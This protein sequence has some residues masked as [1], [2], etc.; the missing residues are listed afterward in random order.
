MEYKSYK[1][2]NYDFPD[3]SI[4]I[5]EYLGCQA[6]TD[7]GTKCDAKFKF[8]T[9]INSEDCNFYCLKHINNWLYK[10]KDE[11]F[12]IPEF[13]SNEKFKPFKIIITYNENDIFEYNFFDN[14]IY[15]NESLIYDIDLQKLFNSIDIKIIKLYFNILTNNENINLINKIN[16]D[17]DIVKKL[18]LKFS[19]NKKNI[20]E[21]M[22]FELEVYNKYNYII[23]KYLQTQYQ[24]IINNIRQ[25]D[26]ININYYLNNIRYPNDLSEDDKLKIYDILR[27]RLEKFI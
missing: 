3:T 8:K 17:Y 23:N 21:R 27:Y 9:N 12:I 20:I 4:I 24:E 7:D 1:D 25:D 15:I 19:Y 26:D 11:E 5:N 6:I 14:K 18:N 10:I 13:K 16:K 22:L 2:L